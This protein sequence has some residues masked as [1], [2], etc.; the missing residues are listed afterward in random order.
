MRRRILYLLT[1]LSVL[2]SATPL[3]AQGSGSAAAAPVKLGILGLGI[4]SGICGIGQGLATKG[5]CEGI[6]RNPGANNNIR[7]ALILGLVLIESLVLY[8]FVLV[9]IGY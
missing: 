6:A 3:F 1:T 4:A 7:T 5:A 2:A 8:I 9:A